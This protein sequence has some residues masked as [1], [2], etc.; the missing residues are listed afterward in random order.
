MS[1]EPF[2]NNF[3]L[4]DTCV[5]NGGAHFF[6]EIASREFM[7]NLTSLL[8]NY[9]SSALNEDVRSKMLELIQSW[10]VAAESRP[11]ASYIVEIYRTLQREGFNFPPRQ[12]VASS[13]FDSNAVSL[14]CSYPL[15]VVPNIARSLQSGQT[16]TFAS[17]AERSSLSRTANTIVEI[18][19]MS[20]V[21][22]APANQSPF[23]TLASLRLYASTMGA[24]QN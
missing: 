7:D 16:R 22:L 14:I 4:T 1:P 20:S 3:Q 23:H 19:A 17:D 9:S 21:G 5:K 24:M 10:A 13:M 6:V 8:K 2:T 11:N 18:A 12:E 15:N